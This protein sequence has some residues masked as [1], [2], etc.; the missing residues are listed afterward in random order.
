MTP[1][2]ILSA[3]VLLAL[4]DLG[5]TAIL[6]AL[7]YLSVDRSGGRAPEALAS[8]VSEGEAARAAEYSKAKLR[9][10]LVQGVVTTAILVAATAA[11]LFGA[12]DRVVGA[13]FATEYWRTA[14]FL[15]IVIAAQALIMTPFE[16]YL[17]FGLERRFGFNATTARTWMVDQAKNVALYVALGLTL[18]AL[19][20]AFVDW[21]GRLWW[22]WAAGGFAAFQVILTSAYPVV[23]APLFNKFE[24]LHEGILADRI[25]ELARRLG[26]RASAI[27]VMDGSRRSLHSNAFFMGFGKRKRIAL[28][29]TLL[30]ETSVDEL[31]AVLAHEI[32]HEKKLHVQKAIA[33]SIG[34]SLAAFFA[35]DRMMGWGALYAAFGFAEP[36]RHAILL[37]LGLA[38]G[39]ATFF[40]EPLLS[41]WSR[42]REYEADAF[43]VRALGSGAPLESALLGQER[44]NAS[45]L[46]PHPL[47]SAWYYSHPT[48]VERIAAIRALDAK[49]RAEARQDA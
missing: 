15:G 3:Y 20:Y 32:G 26:F 17:T 33:L 22:L 31:L 12:L 39:P 37:V 47:Y 6:T 49:L 42:S 43:A 28:Y 36:S 14:I 4:L 23:V 29:D 46:W 24:P 1:A 8:A 9:F 25:G 38:A 18:I 48:L 30:E 40:L 5:W 13:A 19:L 7:N 44:E 34:L 2:S 27:L 41:A 16:L 10:S 45:N 11:G 35:L 21:T